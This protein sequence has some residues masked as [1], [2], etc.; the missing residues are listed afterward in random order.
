MKNLSLEKKR[1]RKKENIDGDV[2]NIS[3]IVIILFALSVFVSAF[4]LLGAHFIESP[5]EAIERIQL[6]ITIVMCGIVALLLPIPYL[7]TKD[8]I[9]NYKEN[10]EAER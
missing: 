1:S 9:D 5:L 4:L 6:A 10:K 2:K 8:L 3:K 7:I